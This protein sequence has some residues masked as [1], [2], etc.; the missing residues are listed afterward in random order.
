MSLRFL[1]KPPFTTDVN[2]SKDCNNN[3]N[4]VNNNLFPIQKYYVF[5]YNIRENDFSHIAL[6][7]VR[8]SVPLSQLNIL[9]YTFLST[10]E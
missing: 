8:T 1:L 7:S 5:G 10:N 9:Q 2:I 3:N 6:I 4:N